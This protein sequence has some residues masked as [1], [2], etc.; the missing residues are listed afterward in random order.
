M[1]ESSQKP[2]P[3]SQD[4]LYWHYLSSYALLLFSCTDSSR[5]FVN[6]PKSMFQGF[7]LGSTW[8]TVCQSCPAIST[9]MQRSSHLNLTYQSK[10][11]LLTGWRE[12]VGFDFDHVGIYLLSWADSELITL[13]YQKACIAVNRGVRMCCSVWFRCPVLIVIMLSKCLRELIKSRCDLVLPIWGVMASSP[14][15]KW[16]ALIIRRSLRF[17]KNLT[18]VSKHSVVQDWELVLR[19]PWL[20]CQSLWEV[21]GIKI[22]SNIL[23][24]M[25][26]LP[27]L[28]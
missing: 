17:V 22:V 3:P 11:S 21:W 4:L 16:V 19:S 7:S 5:H 18:C 12:P 15:V 9:M 20:R 2:Y 14:S 13:R 6:R 1:C 8:S 28:K 25:E 26:G 23:W 10:L 24:S 27:L